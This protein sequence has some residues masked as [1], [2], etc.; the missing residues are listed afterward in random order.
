[1][2]NGN[3]STDNRDLWVVVNEA[4]RDIAELKGR[5]PVRVA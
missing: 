2:P 1:M 4:R 3:E 5:A